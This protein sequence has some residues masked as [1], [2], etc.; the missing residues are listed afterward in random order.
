MMMEAQIAFLGL[1]MG[2]A[3]EIA[4]NLFRYRSSSTYYESGDTAMDTNWWKLASQTMSYVTLSVWGLAAI[5]QLLATFGIMADINLLVWMYVV[6]FVGMLA[7]GVT[8][9]FYSLGYDKAYS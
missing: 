3:V 1:A 2:N 8:G 6:F 4:L 5:T 7:T 9:A